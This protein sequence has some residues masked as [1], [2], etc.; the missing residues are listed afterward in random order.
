MENY[1]IVY[2][3]SD[4]KATR[5]AHSI[6]SILQ[7]FRAKNVINFHILDFGISQV[8][9]NKILALI[10]QY[11]MRDKFHIDESFHALTG[12]GGEL[13]KRNKAQ[14]SVSFR[15]PILGRANKEKFAFYSDNYKPKIPGDFYLHKLFLQ[16]IFADLDYCLF[17]ASSIT[18]KECVS[19]IFDDLDFGNSFAIVSKNNSTHKIFEN[20]SIFLHLQQDYEVKNFCKHF[21]RKVYFDPDMMLLNLKAMRNSEISQQFYAYALYNLHSP[22]KNEIDSADGILRLGFEDCIKVSS[23]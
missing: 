21:D 14:F 9:K 11:N 6:G 22:Y 4:F 1:N 13:L 19:K 10:N 16:D 3:G 12:G 2:C 18:A 23:F 7:R 5:L 8:K 17:L 20:G 15:A